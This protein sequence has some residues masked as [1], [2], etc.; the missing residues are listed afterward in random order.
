MLETRDVPGYLY[1]LSNPSFPGLLKIGMT[2]RL[3]GDRVAELGAA[4]GVPTAFKIEAY[5]ESSD[6]QAHETVVHNS[7]AR[8]R[9]KGKEF[10]RV[11][12]YEAMNTVSK[13]T[14]NAPLGDTQSDAIADIFPFC[15]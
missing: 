15:R 7:L 8:G 13:A 3:V 11:E 4:T 2:T 5:F 10:F 14:G 1:I 12:L 6:P 9:V